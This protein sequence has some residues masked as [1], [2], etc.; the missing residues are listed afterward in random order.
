MTILMKKWLRVGIK[1]DFKN[2]TLFATSMEQ[3]LKLLIAKLVSNGWNN[4]LK[5]NL[6]LVV[7]V[8]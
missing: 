8:V 6:C 5:F 2:C 3:T 1:Y 4:I 7:V